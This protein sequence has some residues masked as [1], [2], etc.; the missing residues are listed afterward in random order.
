METKTIK[1]LGISKVFTSEIF[2]IISFSIIT[3][4][5]AQ[6][7][8]PVQPVPFTLQTVFVV[9]AGAFLGSKNGAYSQLLY[10]A[11]GVVG[12]PVFANGS[13][14]IATLFGPT[15]GYLLAFPIAAYLTGFLVEKSK[16]Y[17]VV[18]AIMLVS[19]LLIVISGT[20]FLSVFY[21]HDFSQALESG[22]AIFSVWEL[23][24]VVA[25]ASIYFGITKTNAKN[26]R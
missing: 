25:A 16:N 14:G 20:L 13:F 12:I 11:M 3:A 22:A 17:F 26:S 1:S 21:L 18:T 9:L 10:L 7:A 19:T 23:A 15:G 8:I 24:K 5:S 2:W 6:V 4:V